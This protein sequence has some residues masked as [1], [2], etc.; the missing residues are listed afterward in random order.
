MFYS[1]VGAEAQKIF[2]KLKIMVNTLEE[3]LKL[4]KA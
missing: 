4:M 2:L 3:V 1:T